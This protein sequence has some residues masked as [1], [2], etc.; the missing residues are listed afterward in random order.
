M[1]TPDRSIKMNN[2]PID[3]LGTGLPSPETKKDEPVR[4]ISYEEAEKLDA[5]MHRRYVPKDRPKEAKSFYYEI[6]GVF[7]TT[8]SSIG[9]TGPDQNRYC[10]NVQKYHRQLTRKTILHE[11]GNPSATTEAEVNVPV[12]H[13]K[14]HAKSGRIICA[15]PMANFVMDTDKFL[16]EYEPDKE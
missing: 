5:M 10:F 9:G 12:E 16:A 4:W 11:A 7:P 13:N 15:D 3:K 8:P 1:D 14:V 2:I 6:L